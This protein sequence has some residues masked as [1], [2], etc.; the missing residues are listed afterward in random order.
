[1]NKYLFELTPYLP[2]NTHSNK[3]LDKISILRLAVQH[4]KNIKSK[5]NR[6]LLNLFKKLSISIILQDS[7]QFLNDSIIRQN[8]ITDNELHSLAIDNADGF[9]LAIKC[10]SSKIVYASTSSVKCI[11]YL[12]VNDYYLVSII[13]LIL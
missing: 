2:I 10:D 3:K 12:P 5:K 8:L 1:M 13:I 6:G 11:N 4:M 9:L 7:S